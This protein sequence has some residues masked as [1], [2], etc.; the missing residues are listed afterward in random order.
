MVHIPFL[1]DRDSL[2][3]H[4]MSAESYEIVGAIRSLEK[5]KEFFEEH[6]ESRRGEMSWE[7]RKNKYDEFYKVLAEVAKQRF[8]QDDYMEILRLGFLK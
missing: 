6:P 4:L 2:F 1:A 8:S 7:E 5:D 3:L